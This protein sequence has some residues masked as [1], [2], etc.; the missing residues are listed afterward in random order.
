MR[1]NGFLGGQRGL[2]MIGFL[3]TAVVVV[4]VAMI[5]F[6]MAPAYIE[7]YAVQKAMQ[8]SLDQMSD[9]NNTREFRNA[10]EGRLNVNYVDAIKAS[11]VELKRTGN[12][13]VA[14]AS[15]ERKLHIA[16]NAYILLEFEAQAS[17]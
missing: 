13:V 8:E 9:I 1:P 14:T 2:S 4:A 10:V 12:A 15:W 17:R 6:R 5:G 3:F 11:D 7:F 16:G